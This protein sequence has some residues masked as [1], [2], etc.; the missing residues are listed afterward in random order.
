MNPMPTSPSSSP[1]AERFPPPTVSVVVPTYNRGDL[2]GETLES[3]RVQTLPDWECLVI[4]D[5]STDDTKSVVRRFAGQDARFRYV[6]QE[7]A[8]VC[9]ARNRGVSLARGEYIAF[10]DSDDHF[11]PDKLEWQV[12]ALQA[13]P[14]AVLV[15]GN[16]LQCK[17]PDMRHGWVYLGDIVDKPS[18]WAFESL[19]QCSS[20]YAPLVRA[21]VFRKTGGFDSAMIPGEDWDMW[22]RIARVGRIIFDPRIHLHYRLHEGSVSRNALR[23]CRAAHRVV[24]KNVR[25]LPPRQRVRVRRAAR[26]NLRSQYTP[27]L[28][29]DAGAMADEGD[30]A[31]ERRFRLSLA[32]LNPGLL[33][34]P[35][36]LLTTLWALLPVGH[37]PPWRGLRRRASPDALGQSG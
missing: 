9:A 18:G 36:T 6:R 33:R 4:D 11:A 10:L 23:M 34:N 8:G 32:A 16:T 27:P 25:D 29:A 3:V 5:G 14:G 37:P 28:Q 35:R 7:N 21:D 24:A 30:W 26:A 1:P 20:I 22:I 15:Y 12:A 2:I 13:D 19:L 31:S 17:P